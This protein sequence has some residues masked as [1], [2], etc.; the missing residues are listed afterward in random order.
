MPMFYRLI[1]YPFQSRFGNAVIDEAAGRLLHRGVAQQGGGLIIF[2]EPVKLGLGSKLLVLEIENG[3]PEYSTQFLDAYLGDGQRK[4]QFSGAMSD[5][6]TR[7]LSRGFGQNFPFAVLF[8]QPSQSM[9]IVVDDSVVTEEDSPFMLNLLANDLNLPRS[10]PYS[11][12]IGRKPAKGVIRGI[13]YFPSNNQFGRDSFTY[14]LVDG[15]GYQSDYATVE[16]EIRPVNDVPQF[17]LNKIQVGAVA[18]EKVVFE[19]TTITDVD[20]AEHQVTWTQTEGARLALSG[21]QSK[22]LTIH[23]PNG[24]LEGEKYRLSVK[25]QDPVGGYTEQSVTI[26]VHKKKVSLLE[27][28]SLQVKYGDEVQ[29]FP[30]INGEVK[31]LNILKAPR[32]GLANIIGAQIIYNAPAER[33]QALYDNIKYKVLLLSGDEWVGSFDIEVLPNVSNESEVTLNQGDSSGGSSSF[34]ILFILCLLS[35]LRMKC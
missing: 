5:Y 24:A 20:S 9:P 18:G 28:K 31:A 1:E 29:L 34:L 12:E 13:T 22:T 16:V 25:V 26:D 10:H 3:T 30:N 4:A 23:V 19:V 15:G 27:T 11:I 7:G 17:K 35:R 33:R 32:N 2:D 21:T 14:R 8:E 6:K